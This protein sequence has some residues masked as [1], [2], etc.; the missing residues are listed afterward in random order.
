MGR[1]IYRLVVET[2]QEGAGGGSDVMAGGDGVGGETRVREFHENVELN[3]LVA[4]H[5]AVGRPTLGVFANFNFET[6]FI[7]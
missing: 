6:D 1:D 3:F 5:V 4:Q 7:I 2:L